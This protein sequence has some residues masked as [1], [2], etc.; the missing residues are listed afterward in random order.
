MHLTTV[1][2]RSYHPFGWWGA[3]AGMKPTSFLQCDPEPWMAGRPVA[4]IGLQSRSLLAA[5]QAPGRFPRSKASL[6]GSFT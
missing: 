6:C 3:V 5:S 4:V 1:I 2:I